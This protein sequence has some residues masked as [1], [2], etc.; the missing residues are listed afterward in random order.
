MRPYTS[1]HSWGKTY[2]EHKQHLEFSSNEFR[3]LQRYAQQI[4]VLFT[5]SAMDP[6][7]LQLPTL[8]SLK[9]VNGAN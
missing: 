6:V 2:G 1:S 7:S 3:E 8:K 5:A 4:G 9:I